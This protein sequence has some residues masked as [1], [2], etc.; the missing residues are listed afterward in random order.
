MRGREGPQPPRV[1]GSGQDLKGPGAA[2]HEHQSRLDVLIAG[3]AR[4]LVGGQGVVE[5]R[6]GCPDQQRPL[7]PV[8]AQEG[9]GRAAA[10][11][12]A[13]RA[14]HLRTTGIRSR[15]RQPAGETSQLKASRRTP[16]RRASVSARAKSGSIA[17]LGATLAASGRCA[18]KTT[19]PEPPRR[20]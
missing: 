2:P 8:T 13:V 12:A 14:A 9:G 3:E 5:A 1:L 16:E 7:L 17:R 20:A 19:R 10:E 6:Q 18:T 11:Q 4:E 15:R